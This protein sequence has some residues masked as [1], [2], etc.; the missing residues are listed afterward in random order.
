MCGLAGMLLS[1][2]LDVA[3]GATVVLTAAGVFLLVLLT[4]SVR[5]RMRAERTRRDATRLS[6]AQV[7]DLFD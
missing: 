4:T 3:S 2:Y 1:Y 7:T 5:R 6:P